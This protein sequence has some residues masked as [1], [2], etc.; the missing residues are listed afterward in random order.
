MY[1]HI[2]ATPPQTPKEN[3]KE[4]KYIILFNLIYLTCFFHEPCCQ[5]QDHVTVTHY[6]SECSLNEY[7]TTLKKPK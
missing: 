7:D 6:S 2:F 4:T 5:R 3:I 1:F